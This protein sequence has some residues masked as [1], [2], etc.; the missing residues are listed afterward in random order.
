VSAT[1]GIDQATAG[2][3][4]HAEVQDFYARQMHMID[5]GHAEAWAAT[6]T[7]DGIFA[8]NAYPQPTV[9]RA[10]IAQAV[11][12]TAAQLTAEGVVHRHWF[13]MLAVYPENDGT[14]RTRYYALV[15]RTPKGGQPVIHRCTVA[16][17]ELVRQQGVW[18]VR[19]R[20]VTRD[21]L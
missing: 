9:G 17:D 7:E 15:I 8:A 5:S 6:F 11:R 3:Q 21:D 18:Q 16:E 12:A 19:R 20:N 1:V 10:A 13:G 14:L 2:P 4:L